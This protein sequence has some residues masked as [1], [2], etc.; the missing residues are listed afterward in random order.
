MGKAGKGGTVKA[1]VV[2]RAPQGTPEDAYALTVPADVP[3]NKFGPITVYDIATWAFIY[4]KEERPGLSSRAIPDMTKNADGNV[5]LYVGP[6]A[7]EGLESNWIP[8]ADMRRRQETYIAT[9]H[10]AAPEA[11]ELD[12]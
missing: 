8:T 9:S 1:P 3:V 12:A 5:T 7:P 11:V 2:R 4:T 10:P 6:K